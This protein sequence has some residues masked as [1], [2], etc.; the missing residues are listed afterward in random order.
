M[1]WDLRIGL[2]AY[3]MGARDLIE[4]AVAADEMGFDS[5]WLGEHIAL[6]VD[7]S[8]SHSTSGTAAHE[9][10]TSAIVDPATRLQLQPEHVENLNYLECSWARSAI[11]SNR[12]DFAFARRVFR[13][14]P[15]YREVRGLFDWLNNAIFLTL[16]IIVMVAVL[17]WVLLR[18]GQRMKELPK[19]EV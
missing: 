10:H 1:S 6:P 19:E 12:R 18:A 13:E 5:L 14:N 3:N 4:L 11:Y 15:H 7:Y 9:H 8:S 17:A 16:A 2:S